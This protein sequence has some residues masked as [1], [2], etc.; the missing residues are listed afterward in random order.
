[1]ALDHQGFIIDGAVLVGGAATEDG[2]DAAQQLVPEGDDG[3]LVSCADLQGVEFFPQRNVSMKMRHRGVEFS[4]AQE[5]PEGR[6]S[7]R[8]AG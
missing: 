5:A 6:V 8:S 3:F 2:V 7:L 1:M 4:V